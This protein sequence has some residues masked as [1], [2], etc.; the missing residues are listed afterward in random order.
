MRFQAYTALAYGAQGIIYSEYAVPIPDPGTANEN[1]SALLDKNG[2]YT[3]AWYDAQKL[4]KH[5]KVYSQIFKGCQ[6][7]LVQI[8][9]ALMGSPCKEL[10]LPFGP[11]TYFSGNATLSLLA[12]RAARYVVAVSRNPLASQQVK[13]KF[14]QFFSVAKI[15]ADVE[16]NSLMET[17]VKTETALSFDLEAGDCLIFKFE[18]INRNIIL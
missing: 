8:A 7:Q 12:N 9:G 1:Y 14:D 10:K 15:V 6:V 3:Q 2:N 16:S 17:Y 11:V 4:N 13:I 5:L 18:V